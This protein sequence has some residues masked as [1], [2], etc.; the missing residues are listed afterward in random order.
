ML[1]QGTQGQPDPVISEYRGRFAPSPTGPLHFGSLFA[2][3]VSY[4]EAK[5]HHGKWLVR[6]EDIDPPRE[7]KGAVTSIISC[8]EHHGLQSDEDILFQ[9]RQSTYYDQMLETLQSLNCLYRCPCSRKQLADTAKHLPICRQQEVEG[10]PCAIKFKA[11]GKEKVWQ[12]GM[13][14]RTSYLLDEDFVLKRKDGL[15]SYQLAVVADDIQQRV[16]HVVRGADLVESTPMQLALY[17]A[18][19]VSPPQYFHFPVVM[20]EQGQK[21]SKQ[22]LA[23]PVNIDNATQNI[24]RVLAMLGIIPGGDANNCRSLLSNAIE[25]WHPDLLATR[26]SFVEPEI[27]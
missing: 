2:A 3:V 12:D 7:L 18:L 21:L 27:C 25:Q 8:L 5:R 23:K 24:Q 15:Y 22:N 19:E 13:L 11:D 9:S 20:N 26:K 1:S 4:L 6:I 17:D 16:T 10:L 14:G